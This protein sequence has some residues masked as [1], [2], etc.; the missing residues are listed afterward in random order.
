MEFFD[1]PERLARI[2]GEDLLAVDSLKGFRRAT[3]GN[4]TIAVTEDTP[5]LPGEHTPEMPASVDR[6]KEFYGVSDEK[7]L[8][9]WEAAMVEWRKTL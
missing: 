7:A 4:I 8:E 5:K 9:M 2:A 3:D 6:F 1:N